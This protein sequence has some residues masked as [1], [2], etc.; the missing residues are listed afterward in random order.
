MYEIINHDLQA[1]TSTTINEC[2]KHALRYKKEKF[3]KTFK[4]QL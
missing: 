3:N 1:L 2:S 4:D